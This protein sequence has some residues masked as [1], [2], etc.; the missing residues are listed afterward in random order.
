MDVAVRFS[1]C[2]DVCVAPLVLLVL[3]AVPYVA[4]RFYTGTTSQYSVLTTIAESD[5]DYRQLIELLAGGAPSSLTQLDVVDV[6]ELAP[7]DY[8]GFDIVTDFHIVD[9]RGWA[10]NLVAVPGLSRERETY[11]FRRLRVR[12][13][14]MA[15]AT[16][17]FEFNLPGQRIILQWPRIVRNSIQCSSGSGRAQHVAG[18][19]AVGAG[20]RLQRTATGKPRGHRRPA[21]LSVGTA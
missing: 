20:F 9:L 19:N 12:P 2:V 10:A 14:R 21:A 15:S 1:R 17:T 13:R 18:C 8:S 6:P 3:A 16:I 7:P 5:S 4:W 11:E